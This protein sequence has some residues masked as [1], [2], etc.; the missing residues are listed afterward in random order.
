[1]ESLEKLLLIDPFFMI[2][3]PGCLNYCVIASL[4]L[5]VAHPTLEIVI[6]SQVCVSYQTCSKF[7]KSVFHVQLLSRATY[8]T[9]KYHKKQ[10]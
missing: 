8:E 2:N 7:L 9:R 3:F 1:M 6:E 5:L 4:A 10:I